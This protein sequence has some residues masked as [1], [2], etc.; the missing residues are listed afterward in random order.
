[1]TQTIQEPARDL[2]VVAQYDVVV[3]GGGIAGVAAALAA[4]RSGVQVALVEKEYGLGGLA[5]LGNVI[6]Y[7]PICDGH[8]QQVIGGVCEELLLRSVCDLQQNREHLGLQK[9]PDCWSAGGSLEER[10]RQRYDARFNPY[11]FQMEM[12][13]MI[14][15][16]GIDLWYDTRLCGCRTADGRISHLIVENKDGR[17]AFACGAVVD[18]SGDAD[19]CALA[20][21]QTESLDS[22]VLAGW[23]YVLKDERLSLRAISKSFDCYTRKEKSE[24]PF[25][26]GDCARD[27]TQHVLQT[28]AWFREQMDELRLANPGVEIQPFAI[29]S[30][31]SFRMTRRLVSSWSLREADDHVWLDDCVAMTGDWRKSGPIWCVPLRSLRGERNHNLLVAGRCMSADTTVWDVTRA[32]P[33]CGVTGEAAGVT[34]ALAVRESGGDVH[35]LPVARVQAEVRARGGILEPDLLKTDA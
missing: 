2:P 31:P 33:T 30:I 6:V 25:F 15:E 22:N 29:G 35:G 34:A 23:H 28:R 9:V 16:A 19:V 12:E 18:A 24:G 27:V 5:T 10:R 17:T 11:A 20:G 8:G 26:A 1:M 32:I 14:G 7:L 3:V 4:A 13:A 21:E